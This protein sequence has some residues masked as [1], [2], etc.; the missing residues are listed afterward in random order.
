M[1]PI[2]ISFSNLVHANHSCTAIGLGIAQ[3]ASMA[4]EKLGD[5]IEAQIYQRPEDFTAYLEQQTP[6]IACFS[7]FIWN[8]NNINL[9]ES[10][11]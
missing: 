11:L 3:V 5:Q 9:D 1:M 6:K 4:N 7:N 8:K 10:T 2:K